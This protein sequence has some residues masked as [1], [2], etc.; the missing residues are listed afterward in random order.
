MTSPILVTGGT[1]TLGHQVVARLQEAGREVR[2][3]S[4]RSRSSKDGLVFA[5][6][7]LAPGE[8]LAAAVR[9]IGTIVHCASNR[10]E[11]AKATRNLVRAT[12]QEKPSQAA[13]PH[14]V[15]ISIVG[16]DRF[17]RGYFKTKLEAEGVIAESGLPSTALRNPVLRADP[18]RRLP[19]R[20]AAGNT[21]PGRLRGPA[22][23]LRR[24]GGA[25]R[26]TR[27]G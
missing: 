3:L 15:Y 27:A 5:T 20:E 26:R 10:K 9:G 13:S 19:P 22:R 16:I 1:G 11:D 25:V 12:A 23:R 6:G 17:P 24:G 4:S 21:G 18:E 8:G 2:V 7:D 14:L